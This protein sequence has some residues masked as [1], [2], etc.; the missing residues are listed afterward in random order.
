[1]ISEE[2]E[3][4]MDAGSYAVYD[5]SGN[6]NVEIA[7]QF[8]ALLR[9]AACA[10]LSGTCSASL[11]DARRRLTLG[12]QIRGAHRRLA[13]LSTAVLLARS[14][15]ASSRSAGVDVE[16]LV[17]NRMSSQGVGVTSRRITAL[18]AQSTVTTTGAV[19]DSDSVTSALS[20]S[21]LSTA[22][23]SRLPSIT[24]EVSSPMLVTPPALPPFSP[25]LPLTPPAP[26]PAS[27]PLPP[28]APPPPSISDELLYTIVLACL[29]LGWAA[30]IW[31][32]VYRRVC[33]RKEAKVVHGPSANRMSPPSSTESLGL[34]EQNAVQV[35]VP[36]F[37]PV[38]EVHAG[39]WLAPS[40]ATAAQTVVEE[41]G[42]RAPSRARPT[43]PAWAREQIHK[44][45]AMARFARARAPPMPSS[46]LVSTVPVLPSQY[47]T[48]MASSG[49]ARE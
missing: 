47:P 26:P 6:V 10:D 31:Y 1:M 46:R 39:E 23:A 45:K 41:D 38:E 21:A 14:Y 43:T 5:S 9:Q 13:R 37:T 30:A 42:E 40:V 2:Q 7:K 25:P 15:D 22:L 48:R 20:G 11:A 19:S 49:E 16:T 3:L 32:V 17:S 29:L 36:S 8:I 33:R 34:P 12:A 24:L 4:T 35:H 27:P 44:V 28:V 18:S